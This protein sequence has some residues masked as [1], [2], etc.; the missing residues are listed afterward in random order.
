MLILANGAYTGTKNLYNTHSPYRGAVAQLGERFNGIE[1]DYEQTAFGGKRSPHH[2]PTSHEKALDDY[3]LSL[4]NRGLSDNYIETSKNFLRHY[5]SWVANTSANTSPESAEK[6]LSQSNHLKLN[7]RKRYADYLRKYLEFHGMNFGIKIKRPHILP[8]IVNEADIERLKDA[9]SKASSWKKSVS[10][11]LAL[12]E[13]AVKTGMRR[14]ELADLRVRDVDLERCR[15]KV[16]AGKGNKDRVIP[17]GAE[18]CQMLAGV[19]A[20]LSED[21]RV[22]GMNKHS[23]GVFVRKWA[24]KA[25]VNLHTHSFRHYFATTL[26]TRGV[27]LRVIQELLGHSSLAT[28]QVYLS[29]TADH[30][31]DAIQLLE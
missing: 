15:V 9:I 29:V 3:L 25:G 30:L 23:L 18:L 14:A 28:T 21:E 6:Y 8:E 16:V 13:T 20:E 19:C 12:I 7:T 11:H 4:K 10:T 17:I 1:E 22:F 24:T 2:P 5:L 27:N 26:A 31:E